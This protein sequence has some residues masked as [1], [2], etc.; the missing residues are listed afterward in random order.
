METEHFHLENHEEVREAGVGFTYPES[1]ASRYHHK[2]PAARKPTALRVQAEHG[3]SCVGGPRGK[4]GNPE[5]KKCRRF[6]VGSG[7]SPGCK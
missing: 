1:A 3:P 4:A 5:E 2:K 7:G 6:L